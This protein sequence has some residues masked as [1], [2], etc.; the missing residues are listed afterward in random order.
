MPHSSPLAER[1]LEYFRLV[2]AGRLQEMYDLY[3]DDVV[4]RRV[5]VAPM[6]GKDALIAFFEGSRAIASIRHDIQVVAVDGNCVAIEGRA[7]ATRTDGSGFDNRIGEFFWFED[8][9]IIRRH[10]YDDQAG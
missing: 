6:I 8:G 3:A 4:Y 9:L 5:G 2:D 7:Q 1:V 10:A